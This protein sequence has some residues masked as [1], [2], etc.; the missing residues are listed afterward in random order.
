LATETSRLLGIIPWKA[1]KRGL[2]NKEPMHT[3]WRYLG[4]TWLSDTDENDMLERLRAKIVDDADLVGTIRVEAVELSNKLHTAFAKR[5][6]E[7]YQQSPST[8]WLRSLREDVFGRGERLI[9]IAHLG[10]H[11]KMKHWVAIELHGGKRELRYADSLGSD[12]PRSLRDIYEWWTNKHTQI[13]L[14][15]GSLPIA[16][17]SDGHSCGMLALNAVEHAVFPNFPLMNQADVVHERL[18]VFN[19]IVNGVLDR[20]FGPKFS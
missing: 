14:E 10:D 3:L 5:D 1:A 7:D 18:I 15:F 16:I 8:R 20:V 12:I 17:Q 9:T 13:P 19:R 11:N 4:P 6:Q 2:S